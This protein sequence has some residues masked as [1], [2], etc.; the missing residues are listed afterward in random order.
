MAFPILTRAW[1]TQWRDHRGFNLL[2]AITALFAALMVWRYADE[3]SGDNGLNV[4][5]R[6]RLVGETRQ[7][8]W[9]QSAVT[10]LMAP[11]LMAGSIACEREHEA[12]LSSAQIILEKWA[13]AIAPMLIVLGALAPLNLILVLSG[14]V[15][16]GAFYTLLAFQIWS[17]GYGAAIGLVCSAWARRAHLALRSAYGTIT[18]WLRIG[19]GGVGS[20]R[21]GRCSAISRRQIT[22]LRDLVWAH[23]PDFGRARPHFDGGQ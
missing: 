8:A 15:S 11:A 5:A 10:L 20:G 14:G 21:S 2:L 17:A 19:R 16:P 7:S 23:Q 4:N 13:S 6:L 9:L 12:P 22:D 18:L 3:S 1:R